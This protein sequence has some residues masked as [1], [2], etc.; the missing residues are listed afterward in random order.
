MQAKPYLTE[1]VEQ[2]NK[3][4]DEYF[5]E[6]EK[7]ALSVTEDE[8]QKTGLP[9]HMMSV[10]HNFCRGGKKLRG[11]LINLGY[12]AAGGQKEE[13]I[14]KTSVAIE[15]IH[16]FLLIHDDVFDKDKIRRGSKTIHL[17][18]QDFHRKN[19]RKG[20]RYHYGISMA[21]DLGDCG[22]FMGME[23]IA[24][25]NFPG[26]NKSKAIKFLSNVLLRTGFG[27]GL[28][29][30][31]ELTEN[32][33]E[34][35]VM[36]VHLNKTAHYTISGPLSVG[37]LLAGT[38][39]KTLKAIENY[40]VPVGI[41]FQ[42]RDDEL[43]LFSTEKTL[44]KPI[45]SDVRE[46]KLTILR[47]K[48]LENAKDKDKEFLEYAYGNRELTDDEVFRV[49]EITEETGALKYSQKI[50]Q[51][52]VEKGKKFVSKITPEAEHQ[53]TLLNLADLMIAR[54]K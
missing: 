40:G 41:A 18:Y 28:D 14:I 33:S 27:Q 24:G 42:L 45:G 2:A 7:F 16:A 5:Q 9:D 34:D 12:L 11:S 4:L 53:D 13:E 30:T 37:A 21:V 20:E 23:K 50:S 22:I 17:R 44:G 39:D 48:A 47:I 26:E 10:Y 19:L 6:K 29:I 25:A 51:E 49:R 38:D 54:G 8:A 1:Y 32:I 46:G 52:L 35:D 15:I 36:R 3:A 31:Y 43:G